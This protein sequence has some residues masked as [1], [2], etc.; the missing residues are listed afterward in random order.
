MKKLVMALMMV[1]LT[2]ST[3]AFVNPDYVSPVVKV[4]N[5]AAPAVVNIEAVG[6]KKASIDPFFEDFY[7]RFFGE[8]PWTQDR[9][10]KALGTGFIFD[11]RG[12]ILTNFH[13]VED[14]D[15]ITITTLEGKKYKAKYVGGDKDLDIAV[16]QV[17]TNDKLP[18]IELGDSDNIQIGEWAIAI[19]NPLG[20][21]HTVTLGVVS[22]VHRKLPK[23]DGQGAYADLIQT[24]AAINPGNSGGP[25]L[26]IHAQVIGIN[27]A[28]VNPQE[29]QNLGFAIPINFA[30][31]FAEALINNGKVSKAYL[32]VYVQDVT[33]SLAKTFGLNTT[34]GAFVSDVVKD[35]PA[36]KAGIKPG[37]VILKIDNKEIDS[38]DELVYIVKTYPAGEHIKV[39]VNR[40]GREIEY[41]VILAEREEFAKTTDKYYLGIKVRD[42][43]PEDI[44]EL[45]LP[46]EMYGVMVED[47]AD[48][49]EAQYINIKKG[50]IIMELYIN[51]KGIKLKS[52]KDFQKYAAKIKK[53]DYIGFI[54]YRDGYRRSIYFK[55]MGK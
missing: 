40:K 50:D 46:K 25:L 51:G 29:G 13:V 49:S 14:A 10:F 8:T 27:T 31:R 4:V 53:G 17:K 47:V 43:T 44:N 1:V 38:A 19:G 28:I 18:V 37:D 30:K 2:V 3:F 15:E 32:G 11:K 6:H 16:L 52:V 33:E 39:V 24:D 54:L 41:E 36:E 22:A 34:K 7:K 35:S 9:E 20:F 23:P 42:L 48:N 5:E 55:Y 12:Y 26:N 21:K 45:N